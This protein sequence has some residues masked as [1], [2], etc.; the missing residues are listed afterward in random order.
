MDR[1]LRLGITG[2]I[3]SGK[4]TVS[5]W[6]RV[7]GI[8]VLDS[9]SIA[10]E[11][12]SSNQII[13]H[14]IQQVLGVESYAEGTLNRPYVAQKIFN[15]EK[16][17]R[18][19]EGIVHPAVSLNMES[20]F[21]KGKPGEII[22]VESALIFQTDLWRS[23]DYIILVESSDDTV[24]E[25]LLSKGKFSREDILRRLYQQQ[26]KENYKQEADFVLENNGTA[27]ELEKRTQFLWT[28]LQI[29][30]KQQLPAIPRHQIEEDE[31]DL[32]DDSS[33]DE[34]NDLSQQGNA[35]IH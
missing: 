13:R 2:K 27:E 22:A 11:L 28:V 1:S 19:V 10:R 24:L 26:W 15:D 21:L 5:D 14:G 31:E 8:T 20:V 4:S 12:M 23:F 30:A 7:R 6:L 17:R 3:G 33:D 25:R 9:D 18:A 16:L 29:L 32:E 35:T 34:S